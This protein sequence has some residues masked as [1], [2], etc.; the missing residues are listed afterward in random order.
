MTSHGNVRRPSGF[1]RRLRQSI[2]SRRC[3]CYC[4]CR[5]QHCCCRGRGR[6]RCCCC[7]FHRLYLKLL[8]H[9]GSAWHWHW[10][11]L[12]HCRPCELF[13]WTTQCLLWMGGGRQSSCAQQRTQDE[14]FVHCPTP[15][16]CAERLC[17]SKSTNKKRKNKSNLVSTWHQIIHSTCV[18]PFLLLHTVSICSG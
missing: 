6:G 2:R 12:F 15:L 4:Y 13:L 9:C 8:Y 17:K 1:P 16:L 7:R 3:H 14:T 10:H 11:C 5:R 18:K